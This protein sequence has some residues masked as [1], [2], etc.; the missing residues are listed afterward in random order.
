LQQIQFFI[1]KNGEL[2]SQSAVE[3]LL[4]MDLKPRLS[5]LA[6]EILKTID[7]MLRAKPAIIENWDY[8]ERRVISAASAKTFV[9]YQDFINKLYGLASGWKDLRELHAY[10][11]IQGPRSIKEQIDKILN[12]D[13]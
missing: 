8:P 13:H 9:R 10:R 2:A 1:A 7:C 5:D 12:N 6:D 4:K 3:S 11:P